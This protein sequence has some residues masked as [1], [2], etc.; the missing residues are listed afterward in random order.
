[1]WPV[2]AEKYLA[3]LMVMSAMAFMPGPANLFAVATGMARGSKGAI[4][5]SLGMN[6]GTLVWFF[7]SGLGLI[8]LAATAPWI[9]RIAGWCGTL[10]IAWLGLD[11]LRSAVRLHAGTSKALRPPGVSVFRD[12]FVVQVTNP[13]ALL[14]FTSVLPPFVAAD[15]PM[16]P[17]LGAFALAV[18]AFDGLFMTS[19]GLMGAAL[20]HKMQEPRIRRTFGV[21][22]GLV[23]ILIA[24]LLARALA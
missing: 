2:S 8:V 19:Y 3:F 23:L 18:F 24:V 1:M 16:L 10:Y 7:A 13:K 22:V 9:F 14:F 6:L 4:L 21:F 5:A 17:Q 12:G 20:A 15:R 11:T